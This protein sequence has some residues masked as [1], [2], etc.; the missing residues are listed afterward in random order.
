MRAPL[1]EGVAA[2]LLHHGFAVLRFNFRGVG[3]STGSH[4]GGEGE[5]LDIDAAIAHLR[6]RTPDV[7]HGVAGWSFG[8]V[9]SL[10][11]TAQR[12]ERMPWVGIAPPVMVDGVARLPDPAHLPAGRRTFIIGDRDQFTTTDQVCSYAAAASAEVHVLPG[13]DH[14]FYVRDERVGDLVVDGVTR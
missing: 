9:T 10:H 11:W 14:F 12:G 1:M 6:D 4:D 13:V 8:A 5:L 2:R 3:A 7:P